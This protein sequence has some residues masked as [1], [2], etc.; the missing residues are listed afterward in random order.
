MIH[1]ALIFSAGFEFPAIT[2]NELSIIIFPSGLS[3]STGQLSALMKGESGRCIS[4]PGR[5]SG[6]FFDP[7]TSAVKLLN[8][9]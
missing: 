1:N 3:I 2:T 9:L 4:S 6:S 5:I 8:A 7:I